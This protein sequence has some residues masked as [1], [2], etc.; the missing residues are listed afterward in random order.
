MADHLTS[1]DLTGQLEALRAQLSRIHHDLNNP[2][3]VISGNVELLA[4]LSDALGVGPDLEGPLDDIS[5]AVDNLVENVDRLLVVRGLI[6]KLT[7]H[8]QGIK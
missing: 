6:M 7:E 2:L 8:L 1:P 4:E 5:T 3:A